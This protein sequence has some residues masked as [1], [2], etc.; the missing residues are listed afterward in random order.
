MSIG[1]RSDFLINSY[2]FMSLA[3]LA[4]GCCD[5]FGQQLGWSITPAATNYMVGEPVLLNMVIYNDSA[6]AVQVPLGRDAVGALRFGTNEND[7]RTNSMLRFG[8]IIRASSLRLE[9]DGSYKDTIV[10]DEWLR[11]PP[12]EHTVLC[13]NSAARME[14]RITLTI[15]PLDRQELSARITRL[16]K[17]A[18][19]RGVINFADPAVRA[20]RAAVRKSPLCKEIIA[21]HSEARA[22]LKSGLESDP[23]D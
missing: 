6:T 5:S 21:H 8:G 17:Q 19:R 3:A 14:T 2:T 13:E 20:L 22:Q 23:T 9:P 16:I 12:G 18:Q 4:V 1:E 11:L 15:L 7:L 10:L